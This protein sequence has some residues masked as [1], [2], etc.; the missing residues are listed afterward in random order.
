MLQCVAVCCG[1]LQCVA[2]CCSVCSSMRIYIWAL[3]PFE[4]PLTHARTHARTHTRTATHYNTLQHTASHYNTLQH[5]ASHCITLHHT[6]THCN[7]LQ[8]IYVCLKL[9]NSP[10]SCSAPFAE[11]TRQ[12]TATH[13]NTPRR[14]ATHCNTLMCVGTLLTAQSPV[15]RQ[16]HRTLQHIYVSLKLAN[17]PASCPAPFAQLPS[18]ALVA[19]AVSSEKAL[20]EREKKCV[21]VRE[22]KQFHF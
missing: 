5:T 16:L 4:H 12:H 20:R 14:T 11:E 22:G 2:V 15:S 13:H 19:R 7:T 18:L 3:T 21:R 1:M 10:A 6:A 17:S 8:H 9:A